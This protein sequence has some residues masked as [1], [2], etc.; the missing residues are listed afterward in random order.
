MVRRAVAVGQTAHGS[1]HADT[2]S[3]PSDTPDHVTG[4]YVTG[5]ITKIVFPKGSMMS[6]VR[7]PQG[8]FFGG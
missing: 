4:D 5:P 6:K 2:F 7:A 8:S 1:S 3:A